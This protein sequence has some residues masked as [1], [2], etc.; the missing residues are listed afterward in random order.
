MIIKRMSLL[1]FAGAINFLA[2]PGCKTH[3]A[4]ALKDITQGGATSPNDPQLDFTPLRFSYSSI[5]DGYFVGY[6]H[7]D[8]VGQLNR[9]GVNANPSSWC[10]V[11]AKRANGDIGMLLYA[12]A[13]PLQQG[14]FAWGYGASF[15]EDV[16]LSY[17]CH[18][19]NLP[20]TCYRFAM[21]MTP[22]SP[23]IAS[24]IFKWNLPWKNGVK[25][26]ATVVD[27][28]K[29]VP[30]GTASV[31]G[32]I[33]DS[34]GENFRYILVT[35]LC[36]SPQSECSIALDNQGSITNY[37]VNSDAR[38]LSEDEVR[39]SADNAQAEID[40]SKLAEILS[41][42]SG[43]LGMR[44]CLATKAC[45]KPPV[46]TCSVGQANAAKAAKDVLTRHPELKNDFCTELK[47]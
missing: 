6:L 33:G 7:K 21:G 24:F 32:Y 23:L 22:T 2:A 45:G 17:D 35:N 5:T 38:P 46:G 27:A 25:N 3:Q 10:I 30:V 47:H 1:A 28:A 44:D 39:S 43:S 13:C 36:S 8:L 37:T 16:P 9:D 12:S 34:I 31:F 41:K 40:K 15:P 20:S 29:L 14:A 4:S 11:P 26:D 19:D 18:V 42:T